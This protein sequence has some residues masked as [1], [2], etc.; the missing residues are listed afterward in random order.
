M[1]YLKVVSKPLA[2]WYTSVIVL[3]FM[4]WSSV[5]SNTLAYIF[6][7]EHV[8]HWVIGLF[9]ALLVSIVL[10]GG[11]QRVAQVATKLVPIMF[12]LYISFAFLIL[13]QNPLAIKDAFYLI[14]MNIFSPAAAKG[15]FLGASVMQAMRYG[16][17]RGILITEAGVGTSSIPHAIADTKNPLDQAILAMCSTIADATLSFLSGLLVLVTGVWATG[18]WRTTLIYEVF[19]QYSPCFGRFV[20]LFA[21]FLFVITTIIGN[22]FNGVQSFSSLTHNRFIFYF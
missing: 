15:A 16:I 10:H 8:P 19:V 9:L 12:V 2:L 13:V 11:A 7:K 18:S 20:L 5:Q 17:Y 14:M 22:S 3:L 4:S 1:E 21:V 6:A